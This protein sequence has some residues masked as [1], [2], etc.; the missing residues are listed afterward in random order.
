MAAAM[1]AVC[2]SE[3]LPLYIGGLF[4]K[5]VWF[6]RLYQFRA[7]VD[8]LYLKSCVWFYIEDCFNL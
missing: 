2:V 6:C 5:P 7:G 1:A 4:V 3:M 8:V